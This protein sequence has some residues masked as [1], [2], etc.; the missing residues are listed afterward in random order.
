MFEELLKAML[1]E[2][3]EPKC[4]E[5]ANRSTENDYY[6]YHRVLGHPIE[7]CFIFKEKVMDLA[8]HGAILLEEDKVSANYTTL[9]VIQPTESQG[10]RRFLEDQKAPREALSNP[11]T[12]VVTF[13]DEDLPQE[14]VDH[15]RPLYVSAYICERRINRMLVDGGSVV[16]ILPFQRLKLLGISTDE[17]QQSR[18]LIQGFNQNGQR[19]LGKVA[20]HL[21]IEEL[22]ITSWFHVIDVRVTYNMLTG[23]PWIHSS[24]AVPSTLHQCL[25]YYKSGLERTIKVDENPFKVEESHF[26][27]AKYY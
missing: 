7:K 13:T 1:I 6:K 9:I 3:L 21:T 11:Q 22:E 5:E 8:T 19:A 10:N 14:D 16:N 24:N 17:L 25:K 23:R 26:V 15:N 18:I 27:E 4:L 20:L 2:L 12:F